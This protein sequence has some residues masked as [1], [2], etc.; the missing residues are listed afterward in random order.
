[1]VPRGFQRCRPEKFASGQIKE[2]SNQVSCFYPNFKYFSANSPHYTLKLKVVELS[3]ILVAIRPNFRS[4]EA[5][6]LRNLMKQ[7]YIIIQKADR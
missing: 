7:K 1:M 2:Q 4:E 3:Q 5:K 6:A